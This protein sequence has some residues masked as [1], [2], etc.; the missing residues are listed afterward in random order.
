MAQ[1]WGQFTSKSHQTKVKDL[2]E[3]LRHSVIVFRE[4]GSSK[5]S[6]TKEKAVCRLAEKLLTARLKF[7]KAKIYNAEPV[8][9]ENQMSQNKR[10]ETLRKQETKV[11]SEGVNGILIEFDAKDLTI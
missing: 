6:T 9:E 8:I 10:M 1:W 11:R 4:A 5:E 7:L 3:A 2:E